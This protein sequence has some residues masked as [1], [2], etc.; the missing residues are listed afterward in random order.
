MKETKEKRYDLGN[1]RPVN[2]IN[3]EETNI[4]VK[5]QYIYS[6]VLGRQ[7][8]ADGHRWVERDICWICEK[9]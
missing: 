4:P 3:I 2:D 9:W 8:I 6:R 1:K 7:E 5:D